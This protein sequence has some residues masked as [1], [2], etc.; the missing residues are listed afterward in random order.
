MFKRDTMRRLFVRLFTVFM[1]LFLMVACV[2]QV[3]GPLVVLEWSGYEQPVFWEEFAEEH[4]D[5]K[6]DYAF[7]A[8]DA[9]AF[10]KLQSGF[11]ADVVHPNVSW[12]KLFVENDL[13]QPVDT[14]KLDNWSGV[15][16]ALAAAGQIDG[17]QY[18]IPWEW[19]Y[20]S[21]LVRTDKVDE[22]PDSWAALW[23]PRYAGKVSIF[24]SAESSVIIAAIVLGYD[25]WNMTDEQLEAVKQKLIEL[26]PNLLGYWTDYTEINQ[27]VAS[28]EVWL[29][30]TWPDAYVAVAG[31][32]VPVEYITPKEGRIGWVYGFC[33][34]RSSQNPDLAHDYIDATLAVDAMAEMANQYGYGASNSAV[35][36]KT[37]P[38]LV[39]LMQLDQ[40][41]VFNRTVFMKPLTEQ[42]RKEWTTLW[43]EVK[44]AQ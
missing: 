10:A 30:V 12:L 40:P 24:D 5:V 23:D 35:I 8:E 33:I 28:G 32:G 21:I 44:A 7:F 19:G 37:D 26:K 42:Q 1:A 13:L 34:P 17:K 20:D 38:E 16:P 29:A 11:Q 25:P 6:V 31:E 2:P 9:E 18:L 43:S 39:K 41:D 27:Q 22:I 15:M 14:S 36:E 4:P 3:K